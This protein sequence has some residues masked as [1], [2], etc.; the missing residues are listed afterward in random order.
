MSNINELIVSQMKT[1]NEFIQRIDKDI[2]NIYDKS[3]IELINQQIENCKNF[4]T[5]NLKSES[6]KLIYNFCYGY[7]LGLLLESHLSQFLAL[8]F[9]IDDIDKK[10]LTSMKGLLSKIYND[11]DCC[12]D[13]IFK[14]C[15]ND[16]IDISIDK[17]NNFRIDTLRLLREHAY[18]YGLYLL[19]INETDDALEILNESEELGHLQAK[20][21]LISIYISE[22]YLDVEKATKLY[23]ELIN[24]DIDNYSSS[25][26][27]YISQYKSFVLIF[28]YYYDNGYYE[29]CLKI[30]EQFKSNVLKKMED[31]INSFDKDN[32]HYLE[33]YEFYK[34]TIMLYQ[35]D[36]EKVKK[37]NLANEELLAKDFDKEI[38]KKMNNAVKTFI[39]TSIKTFE[40]I[41]YENSSSLLNLDYS[42]AT[43]SIYKAIEIVL[44]KIFNCY[45]K[46]LKGKNKIKIEKLNDCLLTKD[47]FI[48]KSLEKFTCG[49]AKYIIADKQDWDYDYDKMIIIYKPCDYFCEFCD[50]CHIKD[51]YNYSK[52]LMQD[53]DELK[54]MRNKTAHRSRIFEEDANQ[55]FEFLL[56]AKKLIKQLYENFDC[57]FNK[58][59]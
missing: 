26:P 57:C 4:K 10:K 16:N 21:L 40:F 30:V 37:K 15:A 14:I 20:A 19:V 5:E 31:N 36:L 35:Q 17:V 54:L 47:G 48:K 3:F 53:L 55:T 58:N 38:I 25:I 46:F 11:M 51:S 2:N 13:N 8:S 41:K 49:D 12:F 52:K 28:N 9:N 22:E 1:E 18:S 42:A 23:D 39:S 45:L 24:Y 29:N 43:I 27:V 50:D 34:K 59:E 56:T 6:D 32:K 33:T 7:F 44:E